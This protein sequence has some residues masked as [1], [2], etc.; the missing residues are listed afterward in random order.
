MQS[1]TRAATLGDLRRYAVAKTLF[2]PTTLGAAIENL[3]FVQ[4]DPIRAPARA[5]DLTLRHRV[6]RYRAGD[7]ERRVRRP[8][9]RGRLLRQLRLRDPEAAGA[10]APAPRRDRARRRGEAWPPARRKRAGICSRSSANGASFTRAR[11]MP[12]SRTARCET[13]G[14]ARRMRRRSSSMRCTT[15]GRSASFAVK[16][17]FGCTRPTS[18]ALALS[19]PPSAT[20]GSTPSWTRSSGIYAP[21]PASTLPF[22]VRRLRFAV[23]AMARGDHGARCSARKQRLAHARVDGVG[24]Y[25][26]AEDEPAAARTDEKVRLLAPFDPVVQDRARFELLWGWVYRF[27]A[28]TPPS[29]RKLGYYALPLLWRERVIGWGNLAVKGGSSRPRSATSA[30]AHRASVRS[31]LGSKRSSRGCAPSWASPDRACSHPSLALAQQRRAQDLHV[32]ARWKREPAQHP[33]SV[34]RKRVLK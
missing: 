5:Q 4:A 27:E 23:P 26:P 16:G 21:L 18:M 11:S 19:T 29:K 7:L 8:R 13:T 1:S 6:R 12:T 15:A 28:Y 31:R 32:R 3:G 9:G 20:R 17:A 30:A 25:W 22:F 14:E 10:D 33:R 2:S 34:H 24:W